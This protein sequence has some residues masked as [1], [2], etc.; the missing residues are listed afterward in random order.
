MSTHR[1]PLGLRCARR[2]LALGVLVWLANAGTAQVPVTDRPANNAPGVFRFAIVAD[3]TGG[4]RPGVFENAVARLKLLQPEFVLSVGDLIDGYTKDPKVWNAEWQEFEKIVARLD[5]PFYYVPGN[6]DI[7]NPE[8]LAAWKQRRGDPWF[9]FVYQQVLFLCLH[10][11]DRTDGGLGAEQIAWAKK[12]LADQA[13]VRWTFVFCHRPLWLYADQA[14]YELVGAALHGRHYTVFS[15]HLHN[16]LKAE[17][18]GMSHYVLATSGGGSKGRGVEY[19]EFDHVTWVTMKPDGPVV[20]NL[21]LD[22]IIPDDVVSEATYPPIEALREGTWLQVDP[23]VH[24]GPTFSRLIVPL[25]LVNPTAYPLHVSGRLAPAAGVHFEP[26]QIDRVVAPGQ[27][28]TVPL[29]LIADGPAVSIHALNEAGVMVRLTGGYRVKDELLELPTHQFLRLDW[30]QVAPRAVQPVKLD[31]RL[32]EWPAD[33]FTMVERPMFITEAWDWS[34]PADGHFRFAVQHHEGK[35]YVAIETFDDHVI[36]SA[37]PAELQDK[38]LVRFSTAAG[39]TMI[40]AV[41]GRADAQ[42]CVRATPTGLL[43]EFVF[44]LPAGAETFHLNL[45]WQDHDRPENTK[46]SVL[47]W[48]DGRVAEFGA[49]TCAP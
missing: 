49:F 4:M 31:G 19:G 38:L 42:A 9:S 5:L 10:S 8:L 17:R 44:P 23:V 20:V 6:H 16:Y 48:R 35:I 37:D 25:R 29:N 22:G 34:G 18:D 33:I 2:T 3:R 41:A 26:E 14:G 36:T 12:T 39:A 43:G 40:E 24:T 46:P 30:P 28:D 15:G 27:S 1:T 11:E 13:G 7:S 45:G 47:W 32:D 21:K